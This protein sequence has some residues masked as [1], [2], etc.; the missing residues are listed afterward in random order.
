MTIR[1]VTMYKVI[2]DGCGAD[3]EDGSDYYA[4]AD[5][6]QAQDIATDSEWIARGGK[7]WCGN[8]IVYDEERDEYVPKGSA[9]AGVEG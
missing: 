9:A 6:W 8:C 1:E 5:A 4:W 3:A 7:H 2:C